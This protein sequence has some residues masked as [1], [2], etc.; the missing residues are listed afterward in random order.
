MNRRDLRR[1]ERLETPTREEYKRAFRRAAL[2][3]VRHLGAALNDEETALLG[4]GS[5]AGDTEILR[6]YRASLPEKEAKR[7]GWALLSAAY[8]EAEERGADPWG[9][10]DFGELTDALDARRIDASDVPYFSG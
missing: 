10:E 5:Q 1:L 4:G 9:E 7:E 8:G 6:R 3:V 2:R